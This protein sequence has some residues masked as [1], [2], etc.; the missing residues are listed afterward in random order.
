MP[1]GDAPLP[2]LD[3]LADGRECSM[4]PG[5]IVFVP[6]FENANQSRVGVSVDTHADPFDA[7][8]IVKH[9]P[10]L[11]LGLTGDVGS[12]ENVSFLVDEH[13]ASLRA[14]MLKID[15]DLVDFRCDLGLLGLER[16]E[17][18]QG[19]GVFARKESV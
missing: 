15:G 17:V 13:T 10:H 18:R 9:D 11:L 1:S 2:C 3:A 6:R 16:L 14:A 4:R 8:A 7:S 5:L 12:S 19:L